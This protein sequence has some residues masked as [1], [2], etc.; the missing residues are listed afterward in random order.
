MSNFQEHTAS[1]YAASRKHHQTWPKLEG[2]HDT[3]ICVMGGGYTGI[4]TAIELAER[5]FKVILLEANRLGW[6]ASGRNGGELIR[7]IGHSLDQFTN[8][9]GQEGVLAL[10]KMGFEALEIVKN[11]I[12]Q[13]QIEC[14]LHLGYAD[15]ATH[16]R[17]LPD[18]DNELEELTQLGY[19]HSIKRLDVHELKREVVNSSF[20]TGALLDEGSGHLHPLNLLLGEAVIAEQLGVQIYEQSEVLRIE[21]GDR[22]RVMTREGVVICDQLILGANAY[23]N[24]ELD[25]WL[26]G[27]ILPAGS[28]LIATKPLD[29]ALCES[30]MP[31]RRAVADMRTALDYY[32][33]S[34]DHRLIF[35]GLCTYTGKDPKNIAEALKPNIQRVFPQLEPLTIAYQWGGMI[36]IGAN[37]LPQIG[38][39]PDCSSIFYAQAYAGHGVNATHLAAKLLA[40]KISGQ[41]E[42]FDWFA[43]V[44]HMTFPGGRR[45]RAPLLAA[46]M[47]WH[48][49]KDAF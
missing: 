11:R 15:L 34:A 14:D 16:H 23:L 21:K 48:K 33:I 5:G 28:Y 42:R 6:G 12:S 7:G 13:Y 25:H 9:I 20:Y 3:Q 31:K 36:G 38:Q 41:S 10:K 30:L 19:P 43:K 29:P 46:G 39:L 27:K 2:H 4:N 45:L 17:H 40:E 18:L 35:G 26:G 37:R 8:C 22:P 44:P 24:P 1:W 49:L 47:L 32:R